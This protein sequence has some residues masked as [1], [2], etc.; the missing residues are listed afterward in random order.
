MHSG[1]PGNPM[2]PMDPGTAVNAVNAAR[3]ARSRER[4]EDRLGALT[5]LAG[6]GP[7]RAQRL[8]SLGV[9]SIRD[10]LLFAPR[11]LVSWEERSTVAEALERVGERVRVAGSVERVRFSRFGRRRSLVR[12]R[13]SDGTAALDALFFNQPW[14]R[15]S[16][17]VGRE[18]ELCGKVAEARG[19]VALVSPR[20]GSDGRPLPA[21]GSFEP[22]YP[23]VRGLG[24]DFLRELFRGA[25]A[26]FGARLV[27]RLPADVLARLGLP[28]LPQAV[29]EVHAPRDPERFVAARRR[30]RLEHMLPVQA[31]LHRRHLGASAEAA[32]PIVL[33]ARAHEELLARYPYRLTAGQ[34]EVARELRADLAGARPMRRLLMGDVGSGKTAVAL[35]SAMAVAHAGGQVAFMAP[36]ELLAEQHFDGL[37]EL[38]ARAGLRAVLLTGSLSAPERRGVLAGLRTGEAGIAF[39]THALFSPDVRYASL[40][41]AIIDEQHRF[42]VGQRAALAGKGDAAHLLLM[43]ATPI[44]RTLALSLYGDVEVSQLRESPPGRGELT[45]RWVRGA[46]L[47]ELP[48]FLARRLRAGE[49]VFWVSPRIGEA[50]EDDEQAT[51]AERRFALLAASE[52]GEF[53]V[54]LVHGRQEAADRAAKLDAFRRGAARVLVATTVIE[55]GVDV[56]AATVMVIE[57]A[58]RLG[59]AQLHQLRGR[60]GRGPRPAWCLLL[61]DAAAAGRFRLL[62]RTRD[63]F[64]LAEEDLRQRGMG[65][66]VGLRQ[67]GANLEGLAGVFA[68][69]DLFEAARELVRERPEVLAAY[70]EEDG[71]PLTP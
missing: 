52:V 1:N 23:T 14:L 34:L 19:G 18:V 44:P 16:L 45:T 51:G 32:R 59:L 11:R 49:Q 62:E 29:G 47:D 26:R 33:A 60:V 71:A 24:Q 10:L 70:L 64:E 6:V 13:V 40:D 56:P 5:E 68:E 58:E 61:G 48:A 69:L 57:S 54:E 63:G 31:R 4:G 17:A 43:T 3:D 25:A 7:V 36:T 42:G 53:G 35:Y 8:A 22:E 9:H 27:E 66:L 20:T 30:L 41:L 15:D 21:P 50:D 37:R 38:L 2:N 55:V 67:S 65:D 46:K 12:V 39:G 28:G